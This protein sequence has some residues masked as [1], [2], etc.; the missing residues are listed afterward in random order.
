MQNYSGEVGLQ[1]HLQIRPMSFYPE[2]PNAA[3]KL[4]SI[5]MMPSWLQTAG[6]L[7]LTQEH[8]TEKK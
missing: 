5:L 2:I 1:Y 6:N 4:Q 3:K 8:S 7:S